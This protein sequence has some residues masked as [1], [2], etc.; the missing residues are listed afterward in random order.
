[1]HIRGSNA[2][3]VDRLV[4]RDGV[5]AV[6]RQREVRADDGLYRADRVALNARCLHQAV[7][8]VTGKAQVVLDRRLGGLLNHLRAAAHARGKGAGGHR[9]ARA[10]LGHAPALGGAD[11]R[12]ALKEHADR[13]GSQKEGAHEILLVL[14]RE[15]DKF[16]DVAQDC[17]DDAGRAE[18]RRNHN[19]AAGRDLLVRRNRP[20]REPVHRRKVGAPGGHRHDFVLER[21]TDR[22]R[23]R[24]LAAHVLGWDA[25][26][27]AL[28]L[29]EALDLARTLWP[30]DLVRVGPVHVAE[31]AGAHVQAA[32]QAAVEL[33]RTALHLQRAGKDFL[34]AVHARADPLVHHAP[35]PHNLFVDF[36]GRVPRQLVL[37]DNLGNGQVVLA[38]EREQTGHVVKRKAR[39]FLAWR[40]AVGLILDVAADGQE[41][42]REVRLVRVRRDT[43][44][45]IAAR[46]VAANRLVKDVFEHILGVFVRVGRHDGRRR[47]GF[48]REP[49]L[50]CTVRR[51]E[52]LAHRPRTRDIGDGHLAVD[53]KPAA[54]AVKVVGCNQIAVH[55][56]DAEA[57]AVRMHWKRLSPLPHEVLFKVKCDGF[58]VAVGRIRILAERQ[59]LVAEDRLVTRW[60][61]LGVYRL[62]VCTFKSK[63]QCLGRH[64]SFAGRGQRAVE[65]N[66]ERV[67]LIQQLRLA[68]VVH[69]NGACAHR[70][71]SVRGRGAN[72][73]RKEVKHGDDRVL[74][75]RGLFAS[76]VGGLV[77]VIAGGIK[78]GVRK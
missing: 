40:G 36:L 61:R 51:L 14:G 5:H 43:A 71:D 47:R 15:R 21:A 24:C 73:N 66:L 12:T 54:D 65:S 29:G 78:V 7:D 74:L 59:D 3:S 37:V 30:L 10:D 48:V 45:A 23:A 75:R 58:R 34:R 38:R 1:M 68:Q 33:W 56:K 70:A 39:L 49:R 2:R 8:R 18:R 26:R 53:D 6:G 60:H 4:E 64:V 9:A 16:H 31:A 22:R 67:G 50:L 42:R 72:T 19:T 25:G 55:V 46:I 62:A 57:H 77:V 69:K 44:A 27:I 35:D 41:L 32:H 11:R 20:A 52:A 76:I 17:G 63:Q 28:R 13:C